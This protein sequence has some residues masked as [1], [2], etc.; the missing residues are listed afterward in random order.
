MHGTRIHSL[1]SE[2]NEGLFVLLE[3]GANTHD[4]VQRH[5]D[6]QL[7]LGLHKMPQPSRELMQE[8]KN[9]EKRKKRKDGWKLV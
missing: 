7:G 6:P 2:T 8:E 3:L 5:G 4:S 1:F 9:K